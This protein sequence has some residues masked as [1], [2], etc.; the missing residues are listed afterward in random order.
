M[1][2]FINSKA[3][4]LTLLIAGTLALG[5]TPVL[6]IHPSGTTT[7]AVSQGKCSSCHGAQKSQQF[8]PSDWQ[9]LDHIGAH[10]R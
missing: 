6:A 10:H 2:E 1:K 9:M 7:L 4:I 8:T 3:G 5:A